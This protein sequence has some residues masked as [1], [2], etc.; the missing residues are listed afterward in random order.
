MDSVNVEIPYV[1][2]DLVIRIMAQYHQRI[3]IIVIVLATIIVII[4]CEKCSFK[5]RKL[6]NLND[7]LQF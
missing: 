2:A 3:P 1:L 6:T 7:E 4:F 5:M